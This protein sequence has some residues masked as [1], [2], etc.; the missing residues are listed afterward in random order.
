M[1]A[2]AGGKEGIGVLTIAGDHPPGLL[3]Q[4][5]RGTNPI[6]HFFIFLFKDGAGTVDE[7]GVGGEARRD[8]TED[9]ALAVGVV[10]DGCGI[11]EIELFWGATPGAAA[12]A[13]DVGENKVGVSGAVWW[14]LIGEVGEE[15]VIAFYAGGGE[16]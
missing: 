8:V 10:G 16:P 14:W 6:G 5:K 3:M 13:G 11:K 7:R 1:A 4:V 15:G 12:G 9:A 2:E